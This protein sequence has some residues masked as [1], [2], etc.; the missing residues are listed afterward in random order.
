M[1]NISNIFK[2]NALV[3][4]VIF[5][6]LTCENPDTNGNNNDKEPESFKISAM[7]FV[8]NMGVGWNL[9]NTLDAPANYSSS[10]TLL[11]LETIWGKVATTEALIKAVKD[12][13]F[14]TIRI[15]VS[16]KKAADPNSDYT[17]RLDWLYR[18]QE[19]VDYA[20]DNDMYVILNTHHDS[21]HSSPVPIF[22]FDDANVE[23]SL[24]A[25]TRIWEQIAENFRDYDE[26]LIFEPLNEPR[27]PDTDWNGNEEKYN[28][29]NRHYQVFVDIVRANGSNN[30]YRFFVFNTYAANRGT[31]PMEGLILPKDTAK[32]KL[33]VSYHAYV[34]GNF[35]FGGTPGTQRGDTVEWSVSGRDGRDA[36]DITEPMDRFYEEFVTKGIPVIIGETGATNK[37]NEAARAAWAEFYVKSAKERGMRVIIWDNAKIISGSSNNN[38]LFGL[39]DRSS[40]KILYPELLKGLLK[41]LE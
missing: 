17:I 21:G 31:G 16:W 10:A 9:G 15:P 29:L 22:R 18:V 7:D 1:K 5:G 40:L 27:T 30:R 12:A 34:P 19:I 28:N 2:F 32:D 25:F 11:E 4:C 38:E 3:L 13:G 36:L 37:E 33:I 23:A 35:A 8:S 39:M 41:G 24:D 20:I 14:N 6:V 26:K